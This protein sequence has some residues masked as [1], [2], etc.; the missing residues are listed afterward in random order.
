MIKKY[1]KDPKQPTKKFFPLKDEDYNIRLNIKKEEPLLKTNRYVVD[2]LKDYQE[3]KKHFLA[4]RY[5]DHGRTNKRFR[6]VSSTLLQ[7]LAH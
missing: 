5:S 1:Y 3:K 6:K 4:P 2:F 7:P